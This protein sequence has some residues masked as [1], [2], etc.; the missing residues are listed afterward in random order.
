[1]TGPSLAR[2]DP[3]DEPK[4]I[5]PRSLLRAYEAAVY[6]ADLPSGRITLEI[7]KAFHPTDE[8]P[9]GVRLAI[10]TAWNPFSRELSDAENASRHEAL[11]EAVHLAGLAS[12]PAAGGDPAGQWKPEMSLA[13]IEPSDDQLDDWMIRFGQNAVVVAQSGGAA[14]LRLHPWA[15]VLDG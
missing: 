11:V 2:P 14:G 8:L 3:A 9:R 10:V 1:M 7:G 15:I 4:V 12:H 5:I 13:I 6:W